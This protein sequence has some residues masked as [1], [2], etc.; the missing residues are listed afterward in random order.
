LE[1]IQLTKTR[2]AFGQAVL[3]VIVLVMSLEWTRAFQTLSLTAV[4]IVVAIEH[5]WVAWGE[6]IKLDGPRIVIV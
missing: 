5:I 1:A 2:A 4:V 3:L 6:P